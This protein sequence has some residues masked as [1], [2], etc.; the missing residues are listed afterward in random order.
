MK[1]REDIHTVAKLEQNTGGCMNKE[2]IK[3]IYG[4][5]EFHKQYFS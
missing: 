4:I 3:Y 5:E 2:G 1:T